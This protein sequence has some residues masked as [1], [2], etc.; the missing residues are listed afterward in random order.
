MASCGPGLFLRFADDSVEAAYQAQQGAVSLEVVRLNALGMLCMSA[1]VSA[2]VVIYSAWEWRLSSPLPYVVSSWLPG[3]A[4]LLT[5]FMDVGI[6]R[7]WAIEACH[8]CFAICLMWSSLSHVGT[9]IGNSTQPWVFLIC[10]LSVRRPC[11]VGPLRLWSLE[12]SVAIV[13]IVDAL[14]TTR[15]GSSGTSTAQ[16]FAVF[17]VVT[18]VLRHV[19]DRAQREPFSDSQHVTMLREENEAQ[20]HK[21]DS[22]LGDLAP[23]GA[24]GE[25]LQRQRQRMIS[26]PDVFEGAG[27]ESCPPARASEHPTLDPNRST[28]MTTATDDRAFAFLQLRVDASD[29]H[30]PALLRDLHEYLNE[31]I[32]TAGL[33]EG[34]SITKS[35]GPLWLVSVN[36]MRP[37]VRMSIGRAVEHVVLAVNI[38]R[39]AVLTLAGPDGHRNHLRGII[40]ICP[41]VGALL[42]STGAP[43]EWLGT[44]EVKAFSLLMSDSF[45]PINWGDVVVTERAV[46]HLHRLSDSDV[47]ENLFA[48]DCSLALQVRGVPRISIRLLRSVSL[49]GPV[50]FE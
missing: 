1:A 43:V 5:S 44:D 3:V 37:S 50:P 10:S 14:A 34:L 24:V 45:C 38:I 33:Y 6:P 12:A 2:V 46:A 42:G 22:L 13:G 23:G 11:W 49:C 19:L 28:V 20:Y 36:A 48:S 39:R 7:A 35:M 25:L 17:F 4:L 31:C 47:T 40:G 9:I 26:T 41:T 30:L 18:F 21:L 16:F 27:D 15:Y 29:E 8:W 32:H